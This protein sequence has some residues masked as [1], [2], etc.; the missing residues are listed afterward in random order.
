MKAILTLLAFLSVTLVAPL[1]AAD[2]V[3]CFYEINASYP[4]C[5]N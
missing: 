1:L 5:K 4:D 2:G 3:D